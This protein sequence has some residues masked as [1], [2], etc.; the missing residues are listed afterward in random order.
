[1]E[2]M[3]VVRGQIS[4]VVDIDFFLNETDLYTFSMPSG[5]RRGI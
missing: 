5:L 4:S 2:S 3:K 1:M